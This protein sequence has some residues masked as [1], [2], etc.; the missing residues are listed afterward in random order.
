MKFSLL[1][2]T[3]PLELIL[4]FQDII[5]PPRIIQPSDLDLSILKL[6]CFRIASAHFVFCNY[7]GDFHS[8]DIDFIS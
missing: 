7:H 3:M 5:I 4:N 8:F 6:L 1:N 2:H